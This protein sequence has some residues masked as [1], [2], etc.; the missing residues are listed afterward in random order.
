MRRRIR[1]GSAALVVSGLLFATTPFLTIGTITPPDETRVFTVASAVN[2]NSLKWR[3]GMA[4][5]FLAYASMVLGLVALYAHLSQ[6][7][8]ERWAFAGLVVTIGALIVYLPLLGIAAYVIPTAGGSDT[9]VIINQTW[10]DPFI[11]LPFIG[12]ILWNV[13]IALLGLAVWRSKTLST[14][15]GIGLLLAGVLGVPGFLDVVVIRFIAPVIFAIGL[16]VS[17]V[18]LWHAC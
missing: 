5:L 15:G 17:G 12:G 18:S 8:E 10:T 1:S 11:M 9:I 6:T 3:I 2:P 14:V 13:G 4:L 16:V 7:R